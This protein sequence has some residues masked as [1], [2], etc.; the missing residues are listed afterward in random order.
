MRAVSY[1][2]AASHAALHQHFTS[3]F[4]EIVGRVRRNG[5]SSALTLELQQLIAGWLV[6]HIRAHD[7]KLAEFVKTAPPGGP[8]MQGLD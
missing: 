8:W 3:E 7:T 2:H 1:P 4:E 5:P 6:L